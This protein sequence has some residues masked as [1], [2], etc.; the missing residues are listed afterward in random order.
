MV[1]HDVREQLP[2]RTLGRHVSCVWVQ[3]VAPGSEP[4][5]HRKAPTGSA[6]LVCELGEAPRIVGP[7]TGLDAQRLQ[8]G[9]TLVGIRLQPAAAASLLGMPASEL[10]DLDVDAAEILGSELA[11][12][13][14]TTEEALAVL[15]R[16][17][18]GLPEPDAVAAE[19]VRRIAASRAA[20][21]RALADEL[22]ISERQL[23]R[24]CEAAVGL[25][26]KTLHRIFRYQ[27]FLALAWRLERP[28]EQL[29]GLAVE[30]GY[31]DQSH[32]TREA[33]RLQGR[34]PRALLLESE[35]RC[36]CGH[37]H[38]ASYAPLLAA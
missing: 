5:T 35:Q 33:V 2:A 28:S 31:A 29:A 34:S 6:E 9:T 14:G 25:T 18:T 17:V 1:D 32:L 27:R 19:A 15:G 22:F 30:A 10:C 16:A 11:E 38:S 24:R 12:A 37:D 7:R 3:E 26:P 36:G 20:D 23:R 13:A 21:V 4:F 8:P